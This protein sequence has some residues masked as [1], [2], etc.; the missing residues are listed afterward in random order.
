MQIRTE[1]LVQKQCS[2]P[3]FTTSSVERYSMIT[4]VLFLVVILGYCPCLYAAS[5]S[6]PP[7]STPPAVLDF[8]SGAPENIYYCAPNGDNSTGDGSIGNPWYDLRGAQG[9]IQPGDVV[10]FRGGDY[11]RIPKKYNSNYSLNSLT[12]DGTAAD[13]I[14]ISNYPGE[15]VNYSAPL[16]QADGT[17]NEEDRV[18]YAADKNRLYTC[19]QDGTTHPPDDP[20]YGVDGTS[21]HWERTRWCMSLWGKHQKLLGTRIGDAYGIVI[22]GGVSVDEDYN[23]VSG[24]EFIKGAAY[25]DGNP[26]MLSIT[27]DD[28]IVNA[29]FSHNYF[30]DS[31]HPV[32]SGPGARMVAIKQFESTN[33]LIEYNLFENNQDLYGNGVI[34]LKGSPEN[35]TIR[36]NKF[37]N[38]SGGI[39]Y[40]AQGDHH[41]GLL[42]YGNLFYNN[43]PCFRYSNEW[44]PGF[45][46]YNNVALHIPGGE[47]FFYYLH[48]DPLGDGTDYGEYYNNVICG[49]G[50]EKG[51][52][53]NSGDLSHMPN[54]FDYNLWCDS[55]SQNG[56][57]E[58][59]GSFASL[60]YHHHSLVASN[61][62]TY[63]PGTKT[64][65]VSDD[66]AGRG[67]GRYGDTI[68]GFTFESV[69]T[70]GVPGNLRIAD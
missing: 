52:H 66:Y 8:F 34:Q 16:W 50:F 6:F 53:T 68:G 67:R 48:G 57:S 26:A 10:Y 21:P 49:D 19:I 11:T 31:L 12:I 59:G 27:M 43:G 15:Q 56:E 51:W 58:W 4:S 60:A 17:Y 32:D 29:V 64:V 65:T 36:Y 39:S 61:A 46:F 41:S 24:V 63:D 37:I 14:V 23:Q 5:D 55:S 62:I 3:M 69:R 18:T 2:V 38:N 28:D 13:P 35:I 44:G 7:T 1:N 42:V 9:S 22:Y 20:T 54:L 33:L 45:R 70:P 40:V 30:H 25:P 47:A